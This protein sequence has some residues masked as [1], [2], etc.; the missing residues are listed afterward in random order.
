MVSLQN[1]WKNQ[2]AGHLSLQY[3]DWISLSSSIRRRRNAGLIPS[4]PC[5]SRQKGLYVFRRFI[6]KFPHRGL[7]GGKG[8][9]KFFRFD[10]NGP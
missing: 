2:S 1:A 10:E 5:S 3:S 7:K 4:A 9:T 6:L 8:P